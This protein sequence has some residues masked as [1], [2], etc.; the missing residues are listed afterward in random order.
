MIQQNIDSVIVVY[1]LHREKLSFIEGGVIRQLS[2][3]KRINADS[4]G[5][6]SPVSVCLYSL[7]TTL[8]SLYYDHLFMTFMTVYYSHKILCVFHWCGW[9]RNRLNDKN[10]LFPPLWGFSL[11]QS[12]Q[13]RAACLPVILFYYLVVAHRHFQGR[14]HMKT[15]DKL[16]ESCQV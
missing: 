6:L 1:C 2:F 4:H 11:H 14:S 3:S 13:S 16:L 10:T 12:T 5:V 9:C 8:F 7:N 15:T